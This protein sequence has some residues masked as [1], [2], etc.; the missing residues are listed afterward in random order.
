M[1]LD[2]IKNLFSKKENKYEVKPVSVTIDIS[3]RCNAACPFCNRQLSDLKRN[4]FM[5]EEMFYEIVKEVKKIKS[6]KNIVLAAFGEP[7]LHPKFDEFVDFLVK[8]KYRVGFPTNM[9]LAD[10][11]FD[12]MLKASHI[13]MSVE[14]WDKKSY[15]ESRKNLN[16]ETT[17]NNIVKFS[18]IV[19]KQKE[20]GSYARNEFFVNKRFSCE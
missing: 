7:M 3:N 14:G 15:D 20:A 19:E 9:S 5:S 12:S 4:N 10:K 6:V 17:Y 13:M 1:L 2:K 11:H 8:N 16:F 18:E